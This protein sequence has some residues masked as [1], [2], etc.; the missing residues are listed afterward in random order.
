[1]K[2]NFPNLK[3]PGP[4]KVN[5]P[6][7]LNTLRQSKIRTDYCS[8]TP[9]ISIEAQQKLQEKTTFMSIDTQ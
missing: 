9:I 4:L 3:P 6:A 8:K 2:K 7:D 5:Q 1:M